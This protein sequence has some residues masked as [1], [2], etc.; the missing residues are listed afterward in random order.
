MTGGH[1]ANLGGLLMHVDEVTSIARQIA[2][3]MR[4]NVDL[5][6]AGALLHDMPRLGVATRA[7]AVTSIGNHYSRPAYNPRV[8]L[9]SYVR[10]GLRFVTRAG[11]ATTRAL[12]DK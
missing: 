1:H 5:V 8:D 2:R 4:A 12:R 3:T 7:S 10:V 9:R 6:V 11:P